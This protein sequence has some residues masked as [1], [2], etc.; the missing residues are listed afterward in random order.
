[1]DDKEI[2]KIIKRNNKIEQNFIKQEK[3]FSEKNI[4]TQAKKI[5]PFIE[6]IDSSRFDDNIINLNNNIN[7]NEEKVTIEKKDSKN[8]NQN[9]NRSSNINEEPMTFNP[10]NNERNNKYFLTFKDKDENDEI[11]ENCNIYNSKEFK[12]L[13]LE[14][15]GSPIKLKED[16]FNIND[17]INILKK[18]IDKIKSNLDKI[19]ENN[20]NNA[21]MNNKKFVDKVMEIKN[22][23]IKVFDKIIEEETFKTHEIQSNNKL[24]NNNFKIDKLPEAQFK[25]NFNNYGLDGKIKENYKSESIYKTQI[26]NL[27]KKIFDCEKENSDLKRVI[28]N[29]RNILEDL[30]YKNKLLS[31]KLIKY[32]TL[33]ENNKYNQ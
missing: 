27:K 16:N 25:L 22:N 33:Y 19:R 32:K 11:E 17:I 13:Y 24:Y 18:L 12:N 30:I 26:I 1:M 29:S 5:N 9:T 3:S 8:K 15:K 31:S 21:I 2:E 28:Q 7:I 4:I 14:E 6:I 23:V 10:N 20:R